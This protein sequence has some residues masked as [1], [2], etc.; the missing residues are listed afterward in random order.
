MRGASRLKIQTPKVQ[1][2]TMI[3]AAGS[4]PA[5][6]PAAFNGGG[7]FRFSKDPDP[8]LLKDHR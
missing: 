8:D 7:N 5:T 3:A 2:E 1:T 6:P 4:R